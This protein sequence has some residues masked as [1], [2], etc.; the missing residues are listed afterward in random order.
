MK[1]RCRILATS[2]FYVHLLWI[3][4][5]EKILPLCYIV[6]Y[7]RG[8]EKWLHND[9][10]WEETVPLQE[11]ASFFAVSAVHPVSERSIE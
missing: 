5:I 6:M 7:K 11:E 2:G 8:S 1:P 10:N 9:E 4:V 3:L